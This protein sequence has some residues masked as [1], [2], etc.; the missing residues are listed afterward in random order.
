M[1]LR[2]AIKILHEGKTKNLTILHSKGKYFFSKEAYEQYRECDSA[3]F[4]LKNHKFL[5]W[6]LDRIGYI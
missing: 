4:L 3:K 6:F 2:E 1:K 5:N